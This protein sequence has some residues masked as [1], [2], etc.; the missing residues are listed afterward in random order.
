MKLKVKKLIEKLQKLDPEATVF[1]GYQGELVPIVEI[2]TYKY[3]KDKAGELEVFDP[4][5]ES[6]IESEKKFKK[7]AVVLWVD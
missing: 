7:Q 1:A 4:D 6:H 5:D 2:N 3:R